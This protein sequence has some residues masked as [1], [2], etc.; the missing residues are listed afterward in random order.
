MYQYASAPSLSTIFD[1]CA[2]VSS[3]ILFNGTTDYV[4]GY[5]Y[6]NANVTTGSCRI[7]GALVKAI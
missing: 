2:C 5:I 1:P 4:E 6:A 3:V 7:T